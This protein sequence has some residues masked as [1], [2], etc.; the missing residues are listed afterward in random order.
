M[1]AIG[2]GMSAVGTVAQM[3]GQYQAGQAGAQ[4]AR[5]QAAVARNNAI[6]SGYNAQQALDQGDAAVTQSQMKTRSLIGAQRAALAANGVDVNSGSALDVQSDSAMLGQLDALT[7]RYNAQTKANAY[8]SQA[9]QYIAQGGLFD[10]QAGSAL[11]ASLIGMGTSLLSGASSV[12]DK[13]LTYKAHGV[14]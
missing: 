8:L 2:L 5:Y 12:G 1:A 3:Y 13:W 9:G 10:Q 7:L 4:A 11:D 14:M 6:V